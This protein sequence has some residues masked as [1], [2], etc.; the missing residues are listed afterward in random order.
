MSALTIAQVRSWRPGDLD[1]A[2]AAVGEASTQVDEQAR[3]LSR[4]LEQ[5]L[6]DARGYW[7]MAASE[8]A[9]EEARTGARLADALDLAR[10]ALRT[11]AT[12]I[13]HAK[14]RLLDTIAGAESEGYTVGDDGRVTAP[15]LPPVMTSPEGAAAAAAE[16]NAEQDRLNDRAGALAAEIGAALA[17]VGSADAATAESLGGIDIPQT[18]ESAVEAYIERAIT[19]RDLLGALG[20]AGGA[21]TLGLVLKKSVG[22]FGRSRSFLDFLRASSAPITDYQTFLRNMGAGDDALRAFVNGAADGGFARFLIGSRAAQVAGKAFLPL[23]VV[24]GAMDAV[25]G[26]GYDGARGWAT[27]GFG[28]AGAAGGGAL[29]ASSAG[30]IALGPVGVGIAGAAVLGYGAW[31]LGNYVYDHWDD[32]TE[33]GGAALEWTGDRLGDAYDAASAATDWA[34]DRLEDAGDTLADVGSSALDTVSFG[35]L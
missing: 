35:L 11:G 16:R 32:I 1:T 22:L 12:D 21:I 20:T 34:G 19:S 23:T 7:A 25:T 5:A 17:G 29:L 31:T 13:G 28:L 27:R 6:T 10:V 30:L 3:A 4:T 33:F 9:A 26:G 2:A 24:T 14:T 8:R 18:L 15:T